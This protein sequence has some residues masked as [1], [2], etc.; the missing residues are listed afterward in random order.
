[1]GLHKVVIPQCDECGHV[2]YLR[3]GTPLDRLPST[4]K[5]AK[6]QLEKS[7]DDYLQVVGKNVYC[8][9]CL[10]DVA[11][12]KFLGSYSATVEYDGKKWT[13]VFV[14]DPGKLTPDTVLLELSRYA[15]GTCKEC[16]H[17]T[18]PKYEAEV[19]VPVSKVKVIK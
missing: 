13:D 6:Q 1:M 12:Q 5:D 10:Y 14:S 4:I 17:T 15:N 9:D 3:D 8:Y 7:S 16:G 18:T 19:N 2:E 11:H